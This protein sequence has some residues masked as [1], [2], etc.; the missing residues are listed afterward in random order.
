MDNK[1]QYLNSY[2]VKY[3]T[4][5]NC[6][7]KTR[8]WTLGR[9]TAISGFV[10]PAAGNL[11]IEV[12]FTPQNGSIVERYVQT[13]ANGTFF[14]SFSPN[15]TGKWTVQATC[16]GDNLHFGSVSESIEFS[17][18]NGN[19]LLSGYMMYVYAAVGIVTIAA[20]AVVVIRRR[21]E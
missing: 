19:S 6:T 1:A 9:N 14:S 16:L 11:T 12:T 5:T 10:K 3:R 8:V 18:V 21:S 20:I 7:L 4:V 17:V 15:A 13:L 2:A